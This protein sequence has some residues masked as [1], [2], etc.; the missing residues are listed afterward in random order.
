M[1]MNKMINSECGD[2][3]VRFLIPQPNFML[4]TNELIAEMIVNKA[5]EH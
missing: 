4:S 2:P 3:V 1:A 5:P